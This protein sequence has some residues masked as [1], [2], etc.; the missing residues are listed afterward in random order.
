MAAG[1]RSTIEV[2]ETISTLQSEVELTLVLDQELARTA[3]GDLLTATHPLVLAALTV[4]GFQNTRYSSLAV[5]K[6][7]SSVALGRYF[8]QL[9]VAE[10]TGVRAGREI[11]GAA[12]D[13][14]GNE[15]SGEVVDLLLASLATGSIVDGWEQNLAIS[16]TEGVLRTSQA[17]NRR[18]VIEAQRREREAS[19]L[20]EARRIS[21]EQLHKRKLDSIESRINTAHSRGNLSVLPAFKAQRNKV[22]QRNA[23]LLRKID[24]SLNVSMLLRSL[25]VCEVEVF[26]D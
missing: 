13:S 5:P 8:L 9:A 15:V 11:W 10:W 1:K 24:E 26:S 22:V 4:P 2:Q 6:R 14:Q 7:E 25:A 23:E 12:V 18:H 16:E 19:A 3:G 21:T 20:T 17:L